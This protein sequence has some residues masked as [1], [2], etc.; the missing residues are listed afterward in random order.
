MKALDIDALWDF[1]DLEGSE[2]R[3]RAALTPNPLSHCELLTQ[4]ART[5][6]LRKRFNEA[7]S[8]L[9]EAEAL[10]CSEPRCLIRIALERG[11]V[12]NSSGG[13]EHARPHFLR[14]WE[15][16]LESG[17]E[18][19]EVDAAHMMAI[20]GTPEESVEWNEKALTTAR[21]SQNPKARKWLGSLLNNLAWTYHDAGEF[22]KALEL[23][24]QAMRFRMEQGKE[25]ELGIARWSVGKCL[26]SLGRLDEALS[27]QLELATDHARA[28]TDDGYVHEE[29]AE[30]LL[31]QGKAGEAGPHFA[32]AHEQLSQDEGFAQKEPDRLARMLSLSK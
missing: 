2:A 24:I 4:I 20:V 14:A 25:P 9:D 22:E 12:F 28:G 21:R 27:V 13:R 10:G 18:D 16:A 29:L 11:R 17:E 30:I 1:Q 23:F 32:R 3:F 26:R 31:A 15:L 19:L 7:H 6:G 5:L 8:L